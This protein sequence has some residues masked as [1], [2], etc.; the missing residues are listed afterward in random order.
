MAFSIFY[1]VWLWVRELFKLKDGRCGVKKSEIGIKASELPHASSWRCWANEQQ[2]E[3]T[4]WLEC[5]LV[6][7]QSPQRTCKHSFPRIIA[8][9]RSKLTCIKFKSLA[10]SSTAGWRPDLYFS[11]TTPELVLLTCDSIHHEVLLD[12]YKA[13]CEANQDSFLH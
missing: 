12:Y 10:Q 9:H 2:S 4:W 11:L 8:R 1:F 13:G 3:A 7:L 6:R 5:R